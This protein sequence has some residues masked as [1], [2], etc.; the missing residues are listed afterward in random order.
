MSVTFS[1]Q[2]AVTGT[3]TAPGV[4]S[5]SLKRF[6]PDLNAGEQLARLDVAKKLAAE[7]ATTRRFTDTLSGFYNSR[8]VSLWKET[9]GALRDETSLKWDLKAYV[10]ESLRY[11]NELCAKQ[12]Q[13]QQAKDTTTSSATTTVTPCLHHIRQECR[14]LGARR[15]ALRMKRNHEMAKLLMTDIDIVFHAHH[16]PKDDVGPLL[17]YEGTKKQLHALGLWGRNHKN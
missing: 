6:R 1:V 2:Y 12:Q 15:I 10:V 5:S 17:V 4:R 3:A 16:T 13:Q 7:E 9:G 8:C 14:A 11:R